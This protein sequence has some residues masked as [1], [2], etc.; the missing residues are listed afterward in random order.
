[1]RQEI[2]TV[3]SKIT[4]QLA[5]M[6]IRLTAFKATQHGA[7]QSARKKRRVEVG[8]LKGGLTFSLTG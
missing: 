3:A 4:A 6:I 1:M 5:A 8:Q 7:F 2:R